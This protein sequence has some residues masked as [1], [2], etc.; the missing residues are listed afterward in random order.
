MANCEAHTKG[1][2]D[3]KYCADGGVYY[4]Y[5]FIEDGSGM[6]HVSYPWGGDLLEDKL[7][8]SLTV[9]RW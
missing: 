3:S 5:N 4:T 6:G 9:S 1:P 7:N 2:P 8:L